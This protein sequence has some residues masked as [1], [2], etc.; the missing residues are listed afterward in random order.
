M[1][2][3]VEVAWELRGTSTGPQPGHRLCL[4]SLGR[5]GPTSHPLRHPSR[6]TNLHIVAPVAAVGHLRPAAM[7]PRPSLRLPRRATFVL[8]STYLGT[9]SGSGY[10][11]G[12]HQGTNL[13]HA[14]PTPS[15]RRPSAR[16][17][18]SPR[19]DGYH[20]IAATQKWDTSALTTGVGQS[21]R[22]T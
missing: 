10:H 21:S 13:G 16:M 17:L 7:I 5:S 6:T 1:N 9:S 12:S 15:T 8:V 4:P 2:Q 14:M 22:D 18:A 11:E 20:H 3:V 19:D